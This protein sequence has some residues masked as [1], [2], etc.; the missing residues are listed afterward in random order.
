MSNLPPYKLESLRVPTSVEPE[1]LYR[2]LLSHCKEFGTVTLELQVAGNSG[3]SANEIGLL[4]NVNGDS[5][6][7]ITPELSQLMEGNEVLY[8]VTANLLSLI[9]CPAPPTLVVVLFYQGP[10]SLQCCH[11]PF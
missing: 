4:L 9:P 2:H 8:R 10:S 1:L 5:L 6:K 7:S 3:P 11:T